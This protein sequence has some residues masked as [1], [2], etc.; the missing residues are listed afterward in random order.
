MERSVATLLEGLSQAAATA[1]DVEDP[2][3]QADVPRGCLPWD[4]IIFRKMGP[5]RATTWNPNK[6]FTNGL[7][8]NSAA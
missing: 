2:P 6:L 8:G 7:M 5:K 1:P 3:V 4:W